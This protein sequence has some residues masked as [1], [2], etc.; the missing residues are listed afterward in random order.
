MRT[1]D[2]LFKNVERL[3]LI[4][5]NIVLS[6]EDSLTANIVRSFNLNITFNLTDVVRVDGRVN[7]S[8]RKNSDTENGK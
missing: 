8:L 3:D 1:T 2:G 7:L 5:N 4:W 6:T